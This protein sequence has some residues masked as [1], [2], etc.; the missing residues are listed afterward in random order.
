M[1][2]TEYTWLYMVREPVVQV[3]FTGQTLVG[4]VPMVRTSCHRSDILNALELDLPKVI[5]GFTIKF[6][7]AH[8]NRSWEIA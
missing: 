2:D 6:Q 8:G 5:L 7:Y 3:H 4:I 1:R